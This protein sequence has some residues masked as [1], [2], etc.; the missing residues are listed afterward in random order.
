MCKPN[1]R[2]YTAVSDLLNIKSMIEELEAEETQL[3][4]EIKAYLGDEE[5]MQVGDNRVTYK[6]VTSTRV[7]TTALKK[8][9]GEEALAPFMKTTT[10]RRFAVC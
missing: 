10:T 2:M 6:T 1:E 4:E 3:T 7:D 5:S 9:L 8:I